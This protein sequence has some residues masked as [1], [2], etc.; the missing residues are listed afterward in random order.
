MNIT[1]CGIY[2]RDDKFTTTSGIINLYPTKGTHWVMF[3]NEFLIHMDVHLQLI[4]LI[5]LKKVSIQKIKFKPTT[6]IVQRI[7]CMCCISQI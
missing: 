6:V 1:D 5:T 4:Y 3:V 7:V 2:M